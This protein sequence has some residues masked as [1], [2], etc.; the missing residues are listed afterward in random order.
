GEAHGADPVAQRELAGG[1]EDSVPALK[2]LLGTP[3]PL[4][5]PSAEGRTCAHEGQSTYRTTVVLLSNRCFVKFSAKERVMPQVFFLTGSS[6]GLGREIAE[7]ALAAGHYL[8][9]TARDP[10]SLAGLADRYG[11]RVLPVRLPAPAPARPRPGR[12]RGRG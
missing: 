3:G 12:R 7:A 2:L 4:V 11:D 8:V 10:A 9:A 5:S 1:A 6:R